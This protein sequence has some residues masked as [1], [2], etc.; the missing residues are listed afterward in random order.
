MILE[1][2]GILLLF[3][4]LINCKRS[5]PDGDLIKN[6]RPYRKMLAYAC[7][8]RHGSS[9]Y[10]DFSV[11][12]ENLEVFLKEHKG[13]YQPNLT[14]CLLYAA[15]V[16]L[17]KTPELNSFCSGNRLYRR[18]GVH[19][20]FT[21]KEELKDKASKV[22]T[23]KMNLSKIDHFKDLCQKMGAKVKTERS[24]KE[25]YSDKEHKFFGLFPRFLFLPLIKLVSF[26]DDY[27]WLPFWF[28]KDDGLFSSVIITNVGSLKMDPAYHHLYEWGNCSL[29]FMVGQIE[30]RAVVEEG[31]LRARRVLPLKITFDERI[32]DGA[33]ALE[34]L[35]TF[36]KV[37]ENP[38]EYLKI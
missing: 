35:K 34:G 6:V 11:K 19:A 20:T 37:L 13:S 14:N 4:I 27:N 5:R 24:S 3:W 29:F 17:E 36:I 18:K 31:V 23:C 15:K 28:F 16:A 30:E 26:I 33:T 7:P 9:V 2:L 22:S 1:A 10:F 38:E 12:V 32:E 8:N 21:V 25:T